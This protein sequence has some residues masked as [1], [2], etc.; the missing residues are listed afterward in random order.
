MKRLRFMIQC[1]PQIKAKKEKREKD[2]ALSHT[3]WALRK[4]KLFSPGIKM[5][6]QS[7]NKMV[8]DTLKLILTQN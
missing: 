7:L 4:E 3:V 5:D 6:I 2:K 8:C 1:H